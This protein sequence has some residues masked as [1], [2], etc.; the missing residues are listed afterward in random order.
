MTIQEFAEK[1]GFM[2]SN[3]CEYFYLDDNYVIRADAKR[4]VAGEAASFLKART[5]R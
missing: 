5:A 2:N 1:Y 3:E 4:E